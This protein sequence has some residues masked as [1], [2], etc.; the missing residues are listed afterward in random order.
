MIEFDEAYKI[1]L[2]AV[3]VL[4]KESVRLD[5]SSG[6]ILAEDIVSDMPMPPFDKAAMDGYA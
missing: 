2:G 3:E 1:V 5:S 6:R 4:G